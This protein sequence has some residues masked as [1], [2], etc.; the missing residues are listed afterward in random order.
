M[1]TNPRTKPCES[2]ERKTESYFYLFVSENWGQN[3]G[4]LGR[5]IHG[6]EIKAC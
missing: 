5:R 4:N 6:A 3:N 1:E 2:E